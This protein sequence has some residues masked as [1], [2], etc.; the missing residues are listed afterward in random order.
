MR[1]FVI[2]IALLGIF[3]AFCNSEE[4]LIKDKYAI[5]LNEQF[6]TPDGMTVDKQGNIILAVPNAHAREGGTWLLKITPDEKVEKYF[7]L[8]P[9]PETNK[10][11]PLG[12]VFG[13]DGNLYICDGQTIGG[14]STHKARILRVVHQNGKPVRSEVLVTGL[15]QA[16]GMDFA[17]GKI[18]FTETQFHEGEKES[19]IESGVFCFDLREFRNLRAPIKVGANGNDRHCIYKF[20]TQNPDWAIGANGI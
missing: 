4:P 17:N 19:P 20:K 7:W 14:D 16:N 15:V 3:Q 6:N 8:K 9:H 18:Y 2:A 5:E 13:S 10:A 12:M 1:H 11:C